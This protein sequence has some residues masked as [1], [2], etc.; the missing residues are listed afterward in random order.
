M[1]EDPDVVDRATSKQ[2]KATERMPHIDFPPI[3]AQSVHPGLT[4]RGNT[5]FN[6]TQ[7]SPKSP[8]LASHLA[9]ATVIRMRHHT[10]DEFAIGDEPENFLAH[11]PVSLAL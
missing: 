2:K 1:V 5:H 4:T 10:G 7:P 3:S 11:N 8:N 9:K 6:G